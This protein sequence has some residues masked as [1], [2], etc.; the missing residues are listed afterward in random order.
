MGC[1]YLKTKQKKY[2]EVY[3][4]LVNS[5]CLIVPLKSMRSVQIFSESVHV[6]NDN[7]Y[8]NIVSA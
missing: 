1:N 5:V 3:S 7:R 8:D 6:F 2:C 4:L